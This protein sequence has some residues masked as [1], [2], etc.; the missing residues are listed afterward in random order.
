[1][2]I[3]GKF[4]FVFPVYIDDVDDNATDEEIRAALKAELPETIGN[5]DE[6]TEDLFTESTLVSYKKY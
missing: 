1:M 6:I 2:R 5:M 3:E 4:S